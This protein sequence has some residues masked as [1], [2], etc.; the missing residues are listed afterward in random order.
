MLLQQN[1]SVYKPG[2]VFQN[3]CISVPYISMA[4]YSLV[5]TVVAGVCVDI[6]ATYNVTNQRAVSR[7]SLRD[8]HVNMA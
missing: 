4:T 3:V 7:I 8:I 6:M 1:I 5:T 2:F